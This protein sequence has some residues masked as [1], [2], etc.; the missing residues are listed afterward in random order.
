MEATNMLK[1]DGDFISE[2][3][4]DNTKR[5][6]FVQC[7]Y[8]F[9]LRHIHGLQPRVGSTALRFGGVW[10]KI[11]EGFYGV[12]KDEG[13]GAKAK[14]I[15]NALLLGKEEWDKYSNAQ[16]FYEDYRTFETLT[17][18]FFQY[19][20]H[21]IGDE[22]F[23]TVIDTEVKFE[24][25]M[26]LSAAE[27]LWLFGDNAPKI[28]FTGKIDKQIKL[29]DIPFINEFKSTGQ[30]V[31]IQAQRLDRLPQ[32]IGY[33]YASSKV[34]DYEPQGVLVSLAK[35]TAR[36]GKSGEYGKISMD[37]DRTPQVYSDG[38][39]EEWRMS[40]LITISQIVHAIYSNYFQRQFDHCYDYNSRC[41]YNNLCI[42]N[43]NRIED[44]HL[45]GY[46]VEYWDVES[47]E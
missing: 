11:M 3:R 22:Q 10:H 20:A 42:Q 33:S 17:E 24:L 44:L 5:S 25:P 39:I 41:R 28:I 16:E 31:Y 2:I 7:P 47:E 29:N 15:S 38:I 14:A 26:E 8:K 32:T 1:Y 35:A 27:Q 36:K 34:F 18:L 9:A 13:W 46:M 23:L 30:D 12:I 6:D 43:K 45:D 21:F 19:L 40:Y 37:F 4:I